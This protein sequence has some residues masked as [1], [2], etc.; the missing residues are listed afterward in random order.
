MARDLYIT[1]LK[2][3][4]LFAHMA[5]RELDALVRQADH[6]RYPA[7]RQVIKEGTTGDEFW[8]V[9]EGSLVVE[10]GGRKVA[11]LGPGDWFGELAVIAPGPRD[12]SITAT[13]PVELMVIS[14]RQFWGTLK[15]S[16]TLM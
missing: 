12:A 4:P 3:V 11:T 2:A 7:R 1:R 8:L 14:G 6:L 10:R 16:P 15:A 5:K 13:T 9:I